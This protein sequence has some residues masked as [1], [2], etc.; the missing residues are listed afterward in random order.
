M[1]YLCLYFSFFPKRLYNIVH[2]VSFHSKC[3]FI[4]IFCWINSIYNSLLLGSVRKYQVEKSTKEKRNAV[5]S[6][7]MSFTHLGIFSPQN[8]AHFEVFAKFFISSDFVKQ[9]DR[10][11]AMIFVSVKELVLL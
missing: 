5:E 9:L 3:I 8:V 10:V 11:S 6:E 1:H 2:G 7:S 4:Y